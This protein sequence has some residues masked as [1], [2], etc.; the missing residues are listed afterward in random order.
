M[1]G[2]HYD[3]KCFRVRDFAEIMETKENPKRLAFRQLLFQVATVCKEIEWEDSG[4][5]S[6]E[7]T[8]K[9]IDNLFRHFTNPEHPFK[10]AAYDEIK[11][12]IRNLECEKT[13]TRKTP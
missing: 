10:A 9:A 13:N 6:K 7:Q 1:S 8:D 2:G 4:D 5:T 12:L 11:N 3:Y